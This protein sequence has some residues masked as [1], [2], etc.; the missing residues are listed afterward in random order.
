MPAV[1]P[2]LRENAVGDEGAMIVTIVQEVMPNLDK[3]NGTSKEL[4]SFHLTL[5]AATKK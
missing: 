4:Q 2:S 3:N 5:A 1:C